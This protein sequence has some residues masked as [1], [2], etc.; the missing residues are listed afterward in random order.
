[1]EILF[2]PS[3]P[4]AAGATAGAPGGAPGGPDPVREGTD[5][6]FQTEILAASKE[7]PVIVD[8]WATWCGPCKQLTPVLEKVVRGAG[9]RVRLVKVDI[10]KNQ[11]LAA[12]FRIQ[13]VP[14]VF[15]IWQGQPVDAFQGA[16]PES[17]VRQFVERLLQSA[18]GTTPQADL[19]AEGR[20]ALEEGQLQDAAELF[21]ALLEQEPDNAA[22]IAGLA[23]TFMAAG[24]E[25]Q[26]KGLLANLNA[27]QAEHA[28]I[29]QVKAA[30]E[31][32]EAGRRAQGEQDQ[33]L[34]RL[35]ADPNDHQARIDMATALNA[36]GKREEAADAL[37]EIIRRDRA[38]NDGAARA[39]LLK[40]FDSWGLMDEA[41]VAARRKLSAL[42][43]S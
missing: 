39:Q 26:A 7:V 12:S 34:A 43:F 32:A 27:V 23:R 10:D 38:W 30:L 16:L 17:Q 42:L 5:A 33:Y 9:G 31:L 35:E 21:S 2:D 15:A 37:L 4:G 29:V 6:N 36:A 25:E 18:G 22:A 41:S 28:D 20:K 11:R 14:T 40:L 24:Q 13:S 8:F 1:M 19:L 3:R